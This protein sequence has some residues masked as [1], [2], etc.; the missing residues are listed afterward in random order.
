MAQRP[1]S[2]NFSPVPGQQIRA[3]S[4]P[5]SESPADLPSTVTVTITDCEAAG[6]VL[7]PRPS[8]VSRARHGVAGSTGSP[9]QVSES[10]G[11]RT[12]SDHAG[13]TVCRGP[14]LESLAAAAAGWSRAESAAGT[15]R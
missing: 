12:E 11:T 7:L 1:L 9:K 15:A 6:P 14:G 13:V 2:S 8:A 4:L 10:T 3:R 5:G